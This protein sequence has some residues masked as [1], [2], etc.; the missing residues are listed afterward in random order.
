MLLL[1]L[2]T[3]DRMKDMFIVLSIWIHEKAWFCYWFTITLNATICDYVKYAT[4]LHGLGWYDRRK[5]GNLF[6][7]ISF[8]VHPHKKV[9]SNCRYCC[10]ST[11]ESRFQLH[12]YVV[13]F[14]AES[15]FHL[16]DLLLW[17]HRRKQ[18]PTA[19]IC[20]VPTA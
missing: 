7:L 6:A 11:A 3:C 2:Y 19:G 15:R 9:N 12:V 8:V 16:Q 14:T 13:E 5:F 18:I 4:K 1:Y 17:T 20:Y 10:I